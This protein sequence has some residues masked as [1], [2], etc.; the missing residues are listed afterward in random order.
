M[1]IGDNMKILCVG[2]VSYD[3]TF[4][5]DEYPTEN[6]KYRVKEKVVGGGGPASNAAYLLGK[7]GMNVYFAGTVGNDSYGKDIIKE[8]KNVNVNTK[9]IEVDK[10]NETTLS[11]ILVN[12]KNGSRT[13][14][15]YRSDNLKLSKKIKNKF[16][17]I[18]VDGQEYEASVEAIKNNPKAIS[19][20]DAG[21]VKDNVISLCKMVNYVVCSKDFAEEYTSMKIDI[22]D[23]KNIEEVLN[24]LNKDFKNVVV[25]LEDKGAMYKDNDVVKIIPSIKVISRDSTGAGDLFHGAFTYCI[26]N[27]FDIEK[28]IKI[29]NITGALS[30]T[31]VGARN[32]VPTLE[33]VMKVYNQNV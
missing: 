19:I 28:T 31:K 16:D 7:W 29:S 18:L 27:K 17:V 33:E 4:P 32:S 1:F 8:F 21:R 24:R 10:N 15:S 23:Q 14:F 25:T 11:L 13:I 22:N 6:I 30:V 26:A 3:I 9:Y 2:N 5:V 12:N 20:I